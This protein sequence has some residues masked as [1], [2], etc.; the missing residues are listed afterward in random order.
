[1]THPAELDL[2]FAE[3]T[4]VEQAGDLAVEILTPEIGASADSDTPHWWMGREDLA[5]AMKIS[6]RRLRHIAQHSGG[7]ILSGDLGYKLT[8]LA[9]KEELEESVGRL[10]SQARKMDTRATEI[11][12]IYERTHERNPLL[13]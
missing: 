8:R 7:Q 12:L 1:M 9:T 13:V 5:E 4:A 11:M 10:R 6:I 3:P 2:E